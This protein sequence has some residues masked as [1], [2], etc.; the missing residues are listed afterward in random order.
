MVII[1]SLLYYSVHRPPSGSEVV[2]RHILCQQHK[3]FFIN[4]LFN[5]LLPG[6]KVEMGK[7]I[8]NNAFFN[9]LAIQEFPVLQKDISS[10]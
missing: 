2:R 3:S 10:S 5:R 4:I 7:F 8:P 9:S 1:R 6:E